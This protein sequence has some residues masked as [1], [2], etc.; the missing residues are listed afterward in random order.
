VTAWD[1]DDPWEP[2]NP[3]NRERTRRLQSELRERLLRWDPIGVAKAPE[4]QD[5]YDC[6]LSPLMHK[7]HDDESAKAIEKWLTSELRDHF[8]MSP[9]RQRE[10]DLA[11]ELV[12]WW[13][14]A[15]TR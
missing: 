11:S 9:D 1:P 12:G 3:Q 14:T 4:A 5:E 8:G 2:G 7:L 6:L 13:T 15:T 10:R